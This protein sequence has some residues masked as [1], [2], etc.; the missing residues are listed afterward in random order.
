ETFHDIVDQALHLVALGDVA[1]ERGGADLVLLEI[2]RHAGRL[3]LALRIDDG[4]V[5]AFGCERVADALPE[6]AIAA[7]DDG[8]GSFQLHC[9]SP[10]RW[11]A[12]RYRIEGRC[13][14]VAQATAAT[15]S[16]AGRP[17]VIALRMRIAPHA[18]PK[19]LSILVTST[20][21]PQLASME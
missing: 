21:W 1:A 10:Y 11:L 13:P 15:C 18:A 3:V 8:G 9:I 4:D 6:P 16:T 14:S 5:A 19:P 7:G 20:P 2:T 12:R 17:A